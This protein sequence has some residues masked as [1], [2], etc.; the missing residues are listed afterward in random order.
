MKKYEKYMLPKKILGLFIF[1][2]ILISIYLIFV[3][4]YPETLDYR[5]SHIRVI[6]VYASTIIGSIYLMLIYVFYCLGEF[7]LEKQKVLY[8]QKQI[9]E[10]NNDVSFFQETKEDYYTSILTSQKEII[11]ML[12]NHHELNQE[13]QILNDAIYQKESGFCDNG[14]V[15]AV[16]SAK[17]NEMKKHHIDFQYT[18]FVPDHISIKSVDL[19]TVIFNLLDNAIMACLV[20]SVSQPTILLDIKYEFKMMKI[21]VKNSY[22]SSYKKEVLK[23]HG[24]GL[25]IVDDIIKKYDGEKTVIKQNNMYEVTLYLGG[26]E[27]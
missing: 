9:D 11:E 4:Y 3:Y 19:S 22:D 8:L 7:Y 23:D 17:Y 12:E 25:K 20:P 10:I 18:L 6:D 27:S 13:F 2:M 1:I 5:T 16:I 26:I 14:I 21:T 15:D 24:Y